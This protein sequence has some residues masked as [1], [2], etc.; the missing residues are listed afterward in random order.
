MLL[1][2]LR[3]WLPFGRGESI[4]IRN[5]C[6]TKN[7][8]IEVTVQRFNTIAEVSDISAKLNGAINSGG[9]EGGVKFLRDRLGT[10]QERTI[11]PGAKIRVWLGSHNEGG[12]VRGLRPGDKKVYGPV[13][14]PCGEKLI[15]FEEAF[16]DPKGAAKRGC[17]VS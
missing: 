7:A 16:K 2:P 6:P 12:M 14:V 11:G 8:T 9:L 3:C 5:V 4:F 1:K 13:A 17:A 10:E 15:I